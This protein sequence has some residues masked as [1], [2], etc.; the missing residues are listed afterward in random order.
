MKYWWQNVVKE[1]FT[2]SA[3]ERK[4]LIMLFLVAAVIFLF[5]RYFPVE[6]ASLGKDAFQKELAELKITVDSSRSTKNY[7]HGENYTDYFRP[8]PN[9]YANKFKGESFYFDP[10][11]LD[12]AGWE[13]LGV[14][15][16]TVNTIQK[17]LAS[18][19]T[20]RQP[21]DIKKIYGLRKDE[22]E[23]LIP[24]IRIA[25]KEPAANPY[26]TENK[27]TTSLASP[28]FESKKKVIDI[29]TADT[30]EFI[31]LPGI[32][33]K[34]AAR[35]VNFRQKLGGFASVEQLGE[36]YGIP[37][38]TFQ[39]IKPRLQCSHPALK[40]ININTADINELRAHPYLRWN[41]ANAII[42]YRQQHG[43][44]KSAED[45]KKIDII[46]DELYNKISPYLSL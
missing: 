43:N 2:F 16:K 22:A 28:A 14:R 21:D 1:Y 26:Y 45:I 33:S 35:I 29:N 44:Y 19:F 4:G 8:G 46:T 39:K 7:E 6:K 3:K 17:F 23:R 40:T 15:D 37:D 25:Q 5:S 36:T 12:A 31:S 42:N 10:N 11:S 18:G 32:G 20:F 13:K 24:Y 38:S 34:L 41:I 30:S 27:N 9:D